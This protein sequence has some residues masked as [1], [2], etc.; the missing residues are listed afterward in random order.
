MLA[1][2]GHATGLGNHA[3]S[4]KLRKFL[5]RS[6]IVT[7]LLIESHRESGYQGRLFRWHR[8]DMCLVVG[9]TRVLVKARSYSTG[10]GGQTSLGLV[11]EYLNSTLE[12]DMG[13]L[14]T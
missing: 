3:R 10:W 9:R 2:L 14:C 1:R 4:D 6:E 7:K 5:E 12:D 8:K 13:S 11:M